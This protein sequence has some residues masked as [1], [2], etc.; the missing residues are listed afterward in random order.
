MLRRTIPTAIGFF[1]GV[2]MLI[3]YFVP[4]RAVTSFAGQVQQWALIV[5]AFAY[6]LGGL[7]ILGIHLKKISR[8]QRDWGYSCVTVLSLL[9]MLVFGFMSEAVTY[10]AADGTEVALGGKGPGS[11]LIWIYDAT[12]VPLGATVF[13]LLCF[14]IASAS[15]RA[16]RIRNW[17]A[18]TLAI[19]ALIVMLSAVPLT[20]KL[21]DTV[22]PGSG[23]DLAY[24]RSWIMEALQNAGKRAILIGV[25][26]GTIATGIKIILGIER[27][28]GTD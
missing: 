13:S 3:D 11:P 26:L 5:V 22:V 24:F 20:I 4:H 27:P 21:V 16:F 23:A 12:Y 19:S 14:Y 7:N 28:Y 17:Q 8:R 18:A 1:F 15:F 10:T 9:V 2:M 25:A 6:A